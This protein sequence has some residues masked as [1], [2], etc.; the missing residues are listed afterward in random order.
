MARKLPLVDLCR[1][2]GWKDPKHALIYYNATATSIA[3]LLD[4]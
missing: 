1:M 3:A 4:K 2:F